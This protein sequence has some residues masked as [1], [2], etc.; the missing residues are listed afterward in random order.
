MWRN[1]ERVSFFSGLYSKW[2]N[3]LARFLRLT[4]NTGGIA[5]EKVGG[6][7]P[8]SQNILVGCILRRLGDLENCLS[9]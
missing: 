8:P 9:N 5:E 6:E 7:P 4:S 2:G 1:S 3:T